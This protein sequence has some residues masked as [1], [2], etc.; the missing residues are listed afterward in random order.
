MT[1]DEKSDRKAVLEAVKEDG[2]AL[3]YASE[4]LKADREIV[5]AAVKQNGLALCISS[6]A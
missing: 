4:D 5:L 3:D 6:N 2:L 1:I